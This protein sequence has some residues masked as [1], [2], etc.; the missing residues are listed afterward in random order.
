MG[1]SRWA[2]WE[3]A[4]EKPHTE[5]VHC[6]LIESACSESAEQRDPSANSVGR[7]FLTL[8][9]MRLL[10]PISRGLWASP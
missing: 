9:Q 2:R 1:E 3:F 7:T 6:A 10:E 5:D 4:V 8:Q